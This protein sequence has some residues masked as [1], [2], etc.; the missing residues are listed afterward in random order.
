MAGVEG[1]LLL[2][3]IV[4][5]GEFLTSL[6]GRAALDIAKPQH[7]RSLQTSINGVGGLCVDEACA[8]TAAINS[9]DCLLS[10]ERDV[11]LEA[12]V[13]KSVSPAVAS[14]GFFSRRACQ[15]YVAV[16]NYFTEDQWVIILSPDVS[17]ASKIEALLG[18]CINLGLRLPGEPTMQQLAALHL[19]AAGEE[20]MERMSAAERLQVYKALKHQFKRAVAYAAQAIQFLNVLPADPKS[21][22][23]D[24]LELWSAA[25]PQHEPVACKFSM[26]TLK[27]AVACIPMRSSR[28][29]AMP[30]MRSSQQPPAPDLNMVGMGN[31]LQQF[32]A[33]VASQMA[34]MQQA[35][36][37]ML[38]ALTSGQS[39]RSGMLMLGGPSILNRTASQSLS[40]AS[41]SFPA[42]DS[43]PRGQLALMPSRLNPS[44]ESKKVEEPLEP[45]KVEEGAAPPKTVEEAALCMQAA[46]EKKAQA[47]KDAKE[48]KDSTASGSKE[49]QKKKGKNEKSATQQKDKENKSQASKKDDSEKQALKRKRQ[50][51]EPKAKVVEESAGRT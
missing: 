23:K 34:S 1:R 2:E 16:G 10:T 51:Q 8:M 17:Q 50:E 43:Q 31:V 5:V 39:Q 26:Q 6:K 18:H 33:G 3:R 37:Q 44:P 42:A 14:A 15:D 45:K 13:A 49:S 7:V 4:A 25:F 11:L 38:T 29:D 12:V 30:F 20:R 22:K 24:S 28:G 48:S 19:L 40:D 35:Q 21:L 41:E 9:I 32:A 27:K 46:M 47:A 36:Q